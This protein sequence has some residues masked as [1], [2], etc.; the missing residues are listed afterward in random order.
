MSDKILLN[1]KELA[2]AL[3]VPRN[4]ITAA[5][6]HGFKMNGGRSTVK[7]Y[8]EWHKKAENFKVTEPHRGARDQAGAASD[9]LRARR[10][11]R[12]PHTA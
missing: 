3:G 8:L 5:K 7:L 2:A 12:V 6:R 10:L 9:T 4:Y 11:K 1:Q